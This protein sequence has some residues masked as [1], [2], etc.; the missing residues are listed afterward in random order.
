MRDIDEDEFEVRAR[1]DPHYLRCVR[2][3]VEDVATARADRTW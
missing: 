1:S 2:Q 3:A